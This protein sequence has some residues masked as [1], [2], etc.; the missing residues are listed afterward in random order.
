MLRIPLAV[1]FVS[2]TCLLAL[3]ACRAGGGRDRD[4]V[5]PPPAISTQ[6]TP[7]PHPAFIAAPD[8]TSA[9]FPQ[10]LRPLT[11]TVRG[12]RDRG[13]I[14]ITADRY[15]ELPSYDLPQLGAGAQRVRQ[16]L[17][18]AC[19]I[20]E[21]AI[22]EKAG[23]Q[24]IPQEIESAI[25]AFAEEAGGKSALLVVFFSG[26]GLIDAGGTLQLFTHYTDRVGDAFRNTIA[27]ADLI[28]WLNAARS[29]ARGRGV[30]LDVVLIVDACR[31]PTLSAPPRAKLVQEETW[32][33]YSTTE[34]ELADAPRGRATP[35]VTALCDGLEALAERGEADLRTTFA[36]LGRRLREANGKQTP[37]LVG[38][39]DGG[40]PKLVMPGRARIG[41]RV[42]DV[43]GDTLVYVADGGVQADGNPLPREGE[44]FVLETTVDHSVQ[45]QV[46]A[47]GYLPFAR[48]IAIGKPDNGKAFAV[49]LRPEFTR[50]RGRV[51]PPVAVEVSSQ[52]DDERVVPRAGYHK[53]KDYTAVNDPE[54]ELLLPTPSADAKTFLLVTQFDKELAR[55]ELD[56][57]ARER[58]PQIDGAHV[59][60]VGSVVL[61][62]ADTSALPTGPDVDAV[63]RMA[64]AAFAQ[65]QFG[66]IRPP[67]QFA[68]PSLQQP[69][70]ADNFQKIRWEEALSAFQAGDLPLARTHLQ[71]LQK[72]LRGVDE[73][74]VTNLLG[75]IEVRLA[76]EAKADA[77]IE[78]Q[79]AATSPADGPLALGL[80]AMLAGRKLRRASELAGKGEL[81]AIAFLR[82]AAM[83]EPEGDSLYAGE[84]RKRVR[85]LRWSIG[86]TLLEKLTQSNRHNDIVKAMQQLRADDP[87]A[88]NDPDWSQLEQRWSVAPLAQFLREGLDRGL[89]TGEW[90]SADEAI[91]LRRQVFPAEAPQQIV[92]LEATIARERVPLSVRQGF[93][94][95]EQAEAAGKLD[96]ALALLTQAREGANPH[97]RSLIDQRD[98]QLREQV[99]RA[100][101]RRAAERR[102]QG[103]LAGT[104]DALLRAATAMGRQSAEVVDLLRQHPELAAAPEVQS[105]LAEID[106]AQLTAARAARSR[107]AWQ[108]YLEDHPQGTGA[109]EAR[110]I[111]ERLADPWLQMATSTPVPGLARY[112]HAMTYDEAHALTLM[113]G[114]TRD[115]QSAL[116]DTWAWDGAQW[117]RLEPPRRPPARA[118]AAMAY[119]PIRRQVLLYGGTTDD[120]DTLLDDTWV[121][122]GSTWRAVESSPRP[123]ARCKH[124]LAFDSDRGRMVL[125]GGS[126][127]DTWEW[128]GERWF[129]VS[130]R[131]TNPGKLESPGMAFVREQHRLLLIGGD[132]RSGVAW[133]WDGRAWVSDKRT[134]VEGSEGGTLVA[135]GDRILRF[136]GEGRAVTN[137]LVTYRD[138]RF[139]NTRM[140][141]P[142]PPRKW[143][144]A[145]YDSKRHMLVVFGGMAPPARRRE[146]ATVFADTWELAVEPD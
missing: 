22:V 12:A 106:A 112:G 118:F 123:P 49:P 47:A 35:F 10:T 146:P 140:G 37:Q 1:G 85:E 83:L 3:G 42:V 58:D 87:E 8:A 131:R 2:L 9:D 63:S 62:A 54:F 95:A 102:A 144:G 128:D 16:A 74:N 18:D 115:G 13:A 21:S 70:F 4:Q 125:Y 141:T 76:S 139:E 130:P 29:R 34:G 104:L 28:A 44:F 142:P 99:F 94:A 59:L 78:E 108:R 19:A 71:S 64:A 51:S 110:A 84:V 33:V 46:N 11:G 23:A 26:H 77:E 56:F 124:A 119:D 41:L 31:A 134:G 114:G 133:A 73:P 24:A 100:E 79:V 96:E 17:A 14:L 117:H 105:R 82:E 137:D 90:L 103:D 67:P 92:D 5:A 52:C 113:H 129:D 68:E 66:G 50:V 89:A 97:W 120:G 60:D 55:V 61:A 30:E 48:A 81:D 143:H 80:R 53:T 7:I 126:Q 32:E 27:R 93:T 15:R 122:D 109:A 111:L 65:D 88:W 136:G 43:L 6:G 101:T 40:G 121:W 45:L 91:A 98:E 38:P 69:S 75:H 39:G 86:A 107:S 25:H 20:P 132:G 135:A 127:R 145:A 36:E 57:G 138:G 116:D 72:S